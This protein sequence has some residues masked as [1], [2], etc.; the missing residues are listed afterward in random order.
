MS[1]ECDYQTLAVGAKIG[2]GFVN[3]DTKEQIDLS[4]V[5]WSVVF[6][7]LKPSA[8]AVDLAGVFADFDFND[9]PVTVGDGTDGR[10]MATTPAGFFTGETGLWTY[11]AIATNGVTGEILPTDV[12]TLNVVETLPA[13]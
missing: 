2:L 7:F 3:C 6:R 4:D 13:P 9:P 11:Q 1:T 12:H 10:F 5:N 8:T